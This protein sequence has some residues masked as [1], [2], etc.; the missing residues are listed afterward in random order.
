MLRRS[1]SFD[2]RPMPMKIAM[3]RPK[4]DD[5][6]EPEVLDDLDVLPGRQLADQIRRGDQQHGE[7]HQVVGHAVAHRFAEDV[8]RDAA[9]GAHGRLP[10]EPRPAPTA[11]ATAGRR[12]PRAC[13]ASGLSDTSRGA[14]RDQIRQEPIRR[15][16]ERQLER[17]AARRDL[18]RRA[19]APARAARA[20]PA[21]T[22]VTTSSQP[23]TS[24]ARMSV[25]GPAPP[26]VRRRRSRRG[27]T[28]PRRPTGCA[29]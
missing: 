25:S 12:S 3:N 13:R 26:A 19:D 18:R 21:V 24:N 23:R 22:P 11:S 2:T 29:S 1:T 4:S 7:E 5:R 16:V 28:A 10:R 9:N 17:V 15:R 6:R 27:C 20:R 14:G 8:D